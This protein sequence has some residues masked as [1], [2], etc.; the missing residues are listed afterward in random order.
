M[1]PLW[2]DLKALK[3]HDTSRKAGRPQLPDI[4]AAQFGRGAMTQI[5]KVK[6][7]DNRQAIDYQDQHVKTNPVKLDEVPALCNG[8]CGVARLT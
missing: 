3:G 7:T 1:K 4:C 2:S 8:N 6:F 5:V